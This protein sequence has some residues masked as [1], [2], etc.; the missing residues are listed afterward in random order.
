[1]LESFVKDFAEEQNG[2]LSFS[3]DIRIAENE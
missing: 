1:M 2:Q 3:Q